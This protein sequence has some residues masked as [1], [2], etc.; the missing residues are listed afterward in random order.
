MYYFVA[1]IFIKD[2]REYQKYLDRSEEVFKKYRG[3]YLAVD[4]EPEILEGTWSYTRHVLIKF[5]NKQDFLNWYYSEEY[6]EILQHRLKGAVCD[7]LLVKGK[8]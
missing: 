3:A 8:I 7:S 5:D 1:N 2:P 6:Q 4:N